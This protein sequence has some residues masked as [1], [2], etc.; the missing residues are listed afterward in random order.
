MTGNGRQDLP[1]VEAL[2]QFLEQQRWFSGSATPPAVTDVRSIARL[3]EDPAVDIVLVTA[4]GG[5]SDAVYHLPLERRADQPDRLAHARVGDADEEDPATFHTFYDALHDRDVTGLWPELIARGATIGDVTFHPVE[6]PE[7]SQIVLDRT[8]IVL[9]GEQSNT[10]LAF[11]DAMVLKVYRRV[12]PGI[13]PDVEIHL[14]LDRVGCPHVAAPLGW[15]D[16][17]DGVLAFLSEYL[18]GGSQGWESAQVSVRDL[19]MEGDLHP[20]DVGGDFAGEAERLGQVTAEVHASLREAFG[21]ETLDADGL[22]STA[23]AM[24]QRLASTAA[25]VPALAPYVKTLGRAFDDLESDAGNRSIDL[26]RVHGDFHL[27]Q[28]M[29]TP[30]GWKL[31]DFEGEPEADPES[32]RLPDTPLRDVAG[33]L[34]SFDYAARLVLLDHPGDTQRAYRASEWVD[35]NSDAF[36]SGYAAASGTDPRED[37]VLLRA[38]EIDKAI[39]E[40]RYESRLRPSWLPIPMQGIERLA[41]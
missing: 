38:L 20:S 21:T 41:G 26:Q 19:F 10:T 34:R 39:Y 6:H 5:N 29:R 24:R 22:R 36:C 1:S 25:E 17:P 2:A 9:T 8:S 15:V 7:G 13:N 11:G 27:G 12:S 28:A 37:A 33:M 32:R 4:S 31:L 3:A 35:H 18:V 30:S 16:S 14:G 40:V 23:E